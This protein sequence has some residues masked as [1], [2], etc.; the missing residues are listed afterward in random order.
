MEISKGGRGRRKE[1]WKGIEIRITEGETGQMIHFINDGAANG[2]H[3][4]I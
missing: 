1:R 4:G 3:K 2:Q